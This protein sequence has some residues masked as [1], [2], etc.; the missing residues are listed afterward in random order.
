MGIRI[1]ALTGTNTGGADIT[2]Y[3]LQIDS[4]GGGS[5]PWTEVVGETTD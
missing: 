2:S 4:T 5:G 3:N 1:T